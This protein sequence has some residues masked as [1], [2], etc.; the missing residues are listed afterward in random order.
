MDK[1]EMAA[2]AYDKVPIYARIAEREKIDV[3]VMD[4][5][6]IPIVDKSY[7]ISSGVST[8]SAEYMGKYI[9]NELIWSRTSGSTGKTGEVFWDNIEMRKSLFSLWCYRKKYYGIQASDKLCYFMMGEA[10]DKVLYQTEHTMAF[11]RRCL[12][13]GTLEDVYR[14]ILEFEPIWMI[15]QPS[16]AVLLCKLVKNKNLEVPRTLRYIEFTGEFLEEKVREKVETIFHCNTANQYGTKEVNS[17]AYECPEGNMHVMS[18]NVYVEVLESGEFCVTSLK[19]RAMPYIR[20]N[21]EDRGSICDGIN[22][23]CGNKN[24][25]LTLKC[26]RKN[27]WIITEAGDKLHPYALIQIINKINY[28][29]DGQL[30]Q[31]QIIQKDYQMFEILAMLEDSE[32]QLYFTQNV[33]AKIKERMGNDV[34]VNARFFSHLIPSEKTGKIASFISEVSENRREQ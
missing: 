12:F 11:S 22:C 18:D 20:F 3:T 19:N 30:L 14:S 2:Y 1:K 21:V 25:I 27:D 26:C 16:I 4:F 10:E 33:V 13:D 31:F 29:M 9:K 28:E 24:S 6:Q 8:L 15:L 32:Y 34:T 7:Y 17:I 5:E 23:S